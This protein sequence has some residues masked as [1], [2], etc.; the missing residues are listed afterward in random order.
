MKT[1]RI[2]GIHPPQDK[3]TAGKPIERIPVAPELRIMLSQS[4]GAPASPIVKPGA[5]VKCGQ[6]IAEAVGV[7]SAPVHS[8]VNGTV[9]KIEPTRT[10]QGIWQNSIV[11]VPDI[12]NPLDNDFKPRTRDEVERLTPEKIIEI[13]GDAGIVGLGGATFPTKVKLT[14]PK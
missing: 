14:L 1:F 5:A 7:V 4:I 8:P 2:G 9:K 6:L 11:I 3:L 13:I 12:E 10:P